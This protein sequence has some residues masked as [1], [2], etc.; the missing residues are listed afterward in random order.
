MPDPLE[1]A[2]HVYTKVFENERIR[3]LQSRLTPGDTTP[4]HSHPDIVVYNLETGRLRFHTAS[5][6]TEEVELPVGT[7]WWHDAAEHATENVGTTVIRS[8]I[9]ELKAP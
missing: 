7:A 4:M 2:S 6:E 9:F 8:L 1:V 3:L 5:G